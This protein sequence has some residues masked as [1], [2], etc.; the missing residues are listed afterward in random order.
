MKQIDSTMDADRAMTDAVLLLARADIDGTK[1]SVDVGPYHLWCAIAALQL[2]WRHP[3]LSIPMKATIRRAATQLARGL[4]A[5]N[6]R[7]L[8]RGWDPAA[9]MA[10]WRPG[11]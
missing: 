11:R 2:A 8:D 1:V 6:R 4:S 5:E 7:A 9:V 3:N 10:D